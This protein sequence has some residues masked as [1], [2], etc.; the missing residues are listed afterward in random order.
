MH[1]SNGNRT[2]TTVAE[3]VSNEVLLALAMLAGHQGL[4]PL[5]IT[6]EIRVALQQV[7]VR[8]KRALPEGTVSRVWQANVAAATRA[9]ARGQGLLGYA[10]ILVLIVL[11]VA[12]VLALLGTRVS[13]ALGDKLGLPK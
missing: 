6:R 8:I 10:L 13:L 7:G 2:I 5:F 1:S 12:V 11:V 3:V 4:D 9:K